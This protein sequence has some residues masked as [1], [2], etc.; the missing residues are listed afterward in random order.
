MIL[1][2][3][4]RARQPDKTDEPK[5]RHPLLYVVDFLM[6]AAVAVFLSYAYLRSVQ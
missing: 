3:R 1:Y 4:I 5:R 2:S 6:L